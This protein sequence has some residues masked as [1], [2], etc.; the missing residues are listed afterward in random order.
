MKTKT[1]PSCLACG[2]AVAVHENAFLTCAKVQNLTRALR[3]AASCLALI[4]SRKISHSSKSIAL[5]MGSAA[6]ALE[7][8][9]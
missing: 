6:K 8:T 7:E 3:H 5:A 9:A 4:Q 1:E 2:K